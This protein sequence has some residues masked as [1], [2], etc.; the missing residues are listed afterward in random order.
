M[1]F[2]IAM[3]IPAILI[4]AHQCPAMKPAD[5]PWMRL[6][7]NLSQASII[8]VTAVQSA[9]VNTGAFFIPTDT[10]LEARVELERK[11]S[12]FVQGLQVVPRVVLTLDKSGR[13]RLEQPGGLTLIWDGK[14]GKELSSVSEVMPRYV[15]A[16]SG[17]SRLGGGWVLLEQ[18]SDMFLLKLPAREVGTAKIDA[19]G[20]VLNRTVFDIDDGFVARYYL[21]P[22]S[23]LPYRIDVE[24]L[25]H[26]PL[27][28]FFD[29]PIQGPIAVLTWT[30][31][32]IEMEPMVD[33]DVFLVKSRLA[34]WFRKN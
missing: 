7:R 24:L 27:S 2:P 11:L 1:L 13:F 12:S 14:H 31:V 6:R 4:S 19:K 15:A 32:G 3:M 18:F 34:D 29:Q 9:F 16:R 22:K 10:P 5:D 25:R 33:K 17:F 23:G 30:D 20:N 8:R 26:G 21:D 28:S